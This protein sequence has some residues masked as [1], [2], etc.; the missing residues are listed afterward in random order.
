MRDLV[1]LFAMSDRVRETTEKFTRQRDD[2][3]DDC[4]TPFREGWWDDKGKSEP[5]WD[6]RFRA[7]KQ[8]QAICRSV[9][10]SEET[11]GQVFDHSL[12]PCA[13]I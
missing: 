5:E 1:S 4:W 13:Y 8:H 9:K 2:E 6:E 10:E 7:R 11:R 3:D 12:M